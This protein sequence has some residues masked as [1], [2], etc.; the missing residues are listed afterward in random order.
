MPELI[1]PEQLFDEK[2]PSYDEE[3][4]LGRQDCQGVGKQS[5]LESDEVRTKASSVQFITT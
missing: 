2:N 4:Q 5:H 1:V 3:D